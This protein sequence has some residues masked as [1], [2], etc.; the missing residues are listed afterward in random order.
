MRSLEEVLGSATKASENEDLRRLLKT[1]LPKVSEK[2]YEVLKRYPYI[3]DLAEE[4]SRIKRYSIENLEG[5]LKQAM[6]SVVRVGGRA[7]YAETPED[8]RRIVG[9]IVGK[10]KIVIKGK[11][12]ISEEIGINEYLR[13]LGN[14]VWETD[15]GM[16]IL[17]AG[18]ERPSHPVIPAV[19]LSKASVA[20]Y[21]KSIGVDVNEKMEAEE[22]VRRVRIFLREKFV[23]ANVGITG[24][25]AFAADTGATVTVENESNNRLSSALPEIHIVLV[26]VDKIVPT[27][28]DALKV[29]M[30]QAAYAG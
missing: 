19:H 11:S 26:S 30:V 6:D 25:N 16:L 20:E 12:M 17:Q 21:L 3:E 15:L 9:G 24:A 1:I 7:Y 29:A 28:E 18:S 4:V 8:A 22:I 13:K 10:G 5:L 23:K 14:E 27:L 2:V